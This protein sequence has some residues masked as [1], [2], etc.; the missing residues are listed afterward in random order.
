MKTLIIEL[1][2]LAIAG[3][4]FY[5]FCLRPCL[6]FS[7]FPEFVWWTAAG[8]FCLGGLSTLLYLKVFG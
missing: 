2:G 3:C 1:L 6:A 8:S 5:L 7:P 4:L